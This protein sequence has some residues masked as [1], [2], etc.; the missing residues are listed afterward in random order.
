MTNTELRLQDIL[1]KHRIGSGS[2]GGKIMD[3]MQ[4]AYELG[5]QQAKN[6]S[7]NP[8]VMPSGCAHERHYSEIDGFAYCNKCGTP[9]S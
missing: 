6:I 8:S 3:A 1:N 4:E 2:W 5:E 9:M 7:S